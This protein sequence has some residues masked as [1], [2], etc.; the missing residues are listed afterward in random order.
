MPHE[1][2]QSRRQARRFL[3]LEEAADALGLG[4]RAVLE[5]VRRGELTGTKTGRGWRFSHEDIDAFLAPVPPG[6]SERGRAALAAS[7]TE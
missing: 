6:T 3:S 4:P 7:L 1:H 2:R 5:Y